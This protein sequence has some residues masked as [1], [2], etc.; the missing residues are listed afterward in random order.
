MS[1]TPSDIATLAATLT[2]AGNV[3][4][5][6]ADGSIT[7]TPVSAKQSKVT[8]SER[9]RRYYE[10]LKSSETVLTASETSDSVDIQTAPSPPP[11]LSPTPPILPAPTPEL[12]QV[13]ASAPT[14]EATGHFFPDSK[15]LPAHKRITWNPDNGWQGITGGDRDSFAAAAPAV[16]LNRQLSAAD[17]WLRAN[18]AKA[19]KQ[20]FYRFFVNWIA[21]QQERG[22]DGRSPPQQHGNFARPETMVPHAPNKQTPLGF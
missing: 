18:P 16:D 3:V 6:T 12:M 1:L 22:G 11:L 9:N 7:A 5:I 13:S 17:L 8:R 21:R 15:P 4:V 20:N 19:K 10:R 14:R 2:A